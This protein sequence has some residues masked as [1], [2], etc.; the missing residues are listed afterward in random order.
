MTQRKG[1][2]RNFRP[3]KGRGVRRY[4]KELPEF[5]IICC[6]HISFLVSCID[7]MYDIIPGSDK[8]NRE[9]KSTSI[10]LAILK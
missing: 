8:V 2:W 9:R 6:M 5:G 3:L 4:N 10:Y 7:I 1:I